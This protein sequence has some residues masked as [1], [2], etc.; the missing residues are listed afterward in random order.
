MQVHGQEQVSPYNSGIFIHI[1]GTALSKP[2][3]FAL[4]IARTLSFQNAGPSAQ[5]FM[6]CIGLDHVCQLSTIFFYY[7][8]IVESVFV[9]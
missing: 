6:L 7:P 2:H 5:A 3:C 9:L 4:V 8:S 1:P